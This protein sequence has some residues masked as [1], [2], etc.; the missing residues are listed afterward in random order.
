MPAE[1]ALI[2]G[3]ALAL[4]PRPWS[5]QL[6]IERRELADRHGR[7]SVAVLLFQDLAVVPLLALLPILAGGSTNIVGALGLAAVK[8]A[9]AIGLI[10]LI[11]RLLLHPIYQ[12]IAETRNPEIFAAMNLLIVLATGYATA[13]A[14]MS[15][16][17]G[18]FLAGLL[19]ADT[20]YR[21]DRGDIQPFR[22]LVP[23][24][25]LHHRRD[26]DRPGA[27]LG[28]PAA[29]FGSD[30]GAA[31]RQGR[32]PLRPAAGL[33]AGPPD[34]RPGRPAASP[35]AGSPSSSWAWRCSSTS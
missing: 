10:L 26:V 29:A 19:L 15:M 32:D 18:A 30:R 31:G 21:R 3:G 14:G 28:Q 20:E 13:Q 34:G 25:V 1:A 23:G 8:A 35:R 22:G 6:L 11:G 33:P 7:L 12:V 2:L 5:V 4:P 27:D 17:L 16:A 24:P 9:V